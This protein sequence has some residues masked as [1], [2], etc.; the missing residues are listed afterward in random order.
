MGWSIGYDNKW[1]RKQVKKDKL[2][3]GRER[4]K[5][6]YGTKNK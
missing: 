3:E 6:N 1:Q 5:N 2:K 4:I